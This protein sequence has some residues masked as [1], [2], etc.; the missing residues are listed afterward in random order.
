MS[1]NAFLE[2][3]RCAV[4]AAFSA[5]KSDAKRR[6]QNCLMLLDTFA[7]SV[8][9]LAYIGAGRIGEGLHIPEYIDRLLIAGGCQIQ[10]MKF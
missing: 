1:C 2:L 9:R 4:T 3:F 10:G 7:V 5:S 6:I 8:V